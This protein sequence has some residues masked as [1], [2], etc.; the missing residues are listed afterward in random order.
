MDDKSMRRNMIKIFALG[1]RYA[2]AGMSEDAFFDSDVVEEIFDD[3]GEPASI[4]TIMGRL[5]A[6]SIDY[7]Q[8]RQSTREL[9]YKIKKNVE[10]IRQVMDIASKI[11]GVYNKE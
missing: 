2:N 11:Q 5:D 6:I 4:E 10:A 3:K 1:I 8:E 9:G 7:R